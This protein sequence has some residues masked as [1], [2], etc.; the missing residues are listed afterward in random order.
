MLERRVA[1]LEIEVRETGA[2]V[3]RVENKIDGHDEALRRIEEAL[4]YLAEDNKNFSK[5]VTEL[6]GKVAH[7][8]GRLANIPTVWQTIAILAS[9]L[10]GLSGIIFTAS[11]FLHP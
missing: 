11:R 3:V 7:I 5:I 1:A 6:R 9:L 10:V 4:R 8:D 2:A